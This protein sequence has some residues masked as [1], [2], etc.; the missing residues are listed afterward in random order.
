MFTENIA[1][2]AICQQSAKF[3]RKNFGGLHLPFLTPV[4]VNPLHPLQPIASIYKLS[5]CINKTVVYSLQVIPKIQFFAN[6]QA[7]E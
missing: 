1:N 6:L 5:T 4:A 7:S 3:A 2:I